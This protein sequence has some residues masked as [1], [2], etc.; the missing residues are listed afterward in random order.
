MTPEHE[1]DGISAGVLEAACRVSLLILDV[2]GV[3]TD[4]GLYYDA[5]GKVCKR[6][7]VQDGLGIWIARKAG[8]HVAVITGQAVASVDARMRDLG[9]SDYFS[10][11]SD[12]RD[13]YMELLQKYSLSQDQAAYVGDD[14]VDLPVMAQVGFPVAVADAQPEVRDIARY[15]TRTRGGNGAVREVIRLLLHSRGMLRQLAGQWKEGLPHE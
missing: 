14:W 11:C 10:G 6:F 3:L 7:H 1:F 15:C 12:K 8:I 5:E 9:I 4:C 13:K 2:D